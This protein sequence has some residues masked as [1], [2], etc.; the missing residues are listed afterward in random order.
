MFEKRPPDDWCR[1]RDGYGDLLEYLEPDNSDSEVD[2]VVN[3]ILK[4][5]IS[6]R[7]L[8]VQIQSSCRNSEI[9]CSIETLLAKKHSAVKTFLFSEDDDE[10]IRNNWRSLIEEAEIE[11]PHK[12][13]EDFILLS[14]V[15]VKLWFRSNLSLP[16]LNV[17]VQLGTIKNYVLTVK[18]ESKVGKNV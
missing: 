15:Y 13:F 5:N 9:V 8:D 17:S 2:K 6:V 4:K 14:K 1:V 16:S 12:C 7:F 18:S 11:D 10:I 3:F